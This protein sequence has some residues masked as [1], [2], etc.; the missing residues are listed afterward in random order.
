MI[1]RVIGM[2]E[3]TFFGVSGGLLVLEQL[4]N[5]FFSGAIG[6]WANGVVFIG[7]TI[8]WSWLMS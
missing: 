3:D 1:P 2:V 6:H 7:M 5:F 4:G 8:L